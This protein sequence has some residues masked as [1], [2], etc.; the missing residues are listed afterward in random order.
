MKS[1]KL[2]TFLGKQHYETVIY[3]HHDGREYETH[4]FPEALVEW[5][6]PAE[7]VVFLTTEVR[8][9]E[10][11]K[12]LRALLKGKTRLLPVN[13]PS[14]RSEEELWKIFDSLTDCL[15][16]NDR[17][18]FDVTHAFRSLPILVLLAASFLRV[19]K[20]VILEAILYGAYEARDETRRVPVFDLTPF[21]SMLDWSTA[22]AR[23]IE[24]GDA[25]PLADLLEAAHRHPWKSAAAPSA[26]LPRYLQRIAATLRNL[27]NALLLS[28]PFE[29]AQHAGTLVRQLNE[30]VQEVERW[31][32][33]F[34]L[35]LARMEESFSPLSQGTLKMQLDLVRWYIK[36]GRITQ[37]IILA[38][39]WLISWVCE[40]LRR[41]LFDLATR[42]EIEKA[43]NQAA[44]EKLEARATSLL[45]KE[46]PLLAYVM[47]LEEFQDL[48]EAWCTIRELR[49]DVAHCGMRRGHSTAARIMAHAQKAL[50]KLEKLAPKEV[51]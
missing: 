28:R 38:R 50:A 11:W 8:A 32:P 7:V 4:L 12:K 36:L 17:V 47:E 27:S 46:S 2:L 34:A 24:T 21:I 3:R 33:P 22:T 6:R 13:I 48:L 44:R 45:E 25:Q 19:A 15:D 9:H 41:D 1:M 30:A 51:P 16:E 23:F 10:N 29:V 37:A 14:G 20:S 35:L 43:L 18:I 31:A 42:Q 5:Y 26:E 40:A 49:N 39:E